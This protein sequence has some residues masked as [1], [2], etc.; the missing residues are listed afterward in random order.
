[1]SRHSAIAHTSSYVQTRIRLIHQT[2]HRLV[3]GLNN[4]KSDQ[5]ERVLR[6]GSRVE[7]V[8][9]K[10]IGEEV[11]DT[12]RGVANVESVLTTYYVRG[13]D[14]PRIVASAVGEHTEEIEDKNRN[15]KRADAEQ[16]DVGSDESVPRLGI[17]VGGGGI[18]RLPGDR[19]PYRPETAW[20]LLLRRHIL[21]NVPAATS[22]CIYLMY[23]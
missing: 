17:L 21:E 3:G 8:A 14:L 16:F 9:E 7:F 22:S 10:Q 12:H 15:E 11:E 4:G 13:T 5:Q 6:E 18:G 20:Q 23:T 1:M 19:E 2:E